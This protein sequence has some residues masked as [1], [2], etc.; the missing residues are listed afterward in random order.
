MSSYATVPRRETPGPGPTPSAAKSTSRIP[1]LDFTKGML[2][3]I[4]VLYHWLNYFFGMRGDVY[5]YLRFLTPSFIFITG[6]L[7]SHV[8]LAKYDPAD[9]RLPKRLSV[10]GLKILGIF[11]LLNLGAILLRPTS[12]NGRALF[13]NWT[14]IDVMKSYITGNVV[15]ANNGKAAAF[16][17]LLPIG[18]LLLLT[19]GLAPVTR[20]FRYAFHAVCGVFLLGVF[21]LY[22][23][24][25]ESANLELLGIGLLGVVCGYFPDKK[26]NRLC[27]SPFLCLAAYAC[28]T[29][30]ITISPVVY[31][32]LQIAGVCLTLMLLYLMGTKEWRPARLR[33]HIVLLGKYS[34]FGYMAQITIIQLL[35]KA[36]PRI[37]MGEAGLMIVSFCA[38][39]GLT[40]LT[41]EA[42]HRI[43][44][45]VTPVDRIYTAV[46]A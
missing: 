17:I 37:P 41:V 38:S 20:F 10:R 23:A 19:A 11:I 8:Y 6:F 40:M 39:F 5:K 4:M 3:L 26:I 16:F 1:S 36:L 28:Y 45:K 35:H 27:A 18:Y 25:M 33:E 29:A 32:P 22:M 12:A 34:L 31:Y 42:L 46:F 15:T 14:F 30:A 13:A 2:V 7:V 9:P 24:G 44:R 43:R 21:A